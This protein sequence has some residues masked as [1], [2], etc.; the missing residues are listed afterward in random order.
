MFKGYEAGNSAITSLYCPI[1]IKHGHYGLNISMSQTETTAPEQILP[2]P[3][4]ITRSF[5]F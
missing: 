4:S 2:S 3:G 5:F 1:A